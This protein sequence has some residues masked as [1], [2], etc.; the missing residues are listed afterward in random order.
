MKSIPDFIWPCHITGLK[1]KNSYEESTPLSVFRKCI[2]VMTTSLE[3][4]CLP[5]KTKIKSTANRLEIYNDI[6]LTSCVIAK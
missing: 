3:S 4:A 5:L 1:G 6:A 2:N